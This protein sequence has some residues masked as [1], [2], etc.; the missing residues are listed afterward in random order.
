MLTHNVQ[1]KKHH[2]GNR[3]LKKERNG[4]IE[5]VR[6]R[7]ISGDSELINLTEGCEEDAGSVKRRRKSKE[8]ESIDLTNDDD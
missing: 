5:P 7:I 6:R 4:D 3:S 8:G 1:Q 2:N